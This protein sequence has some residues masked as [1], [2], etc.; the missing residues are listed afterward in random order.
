MRLVFVLFDSLNRLALQSYGGGLETPNFQRLADRSVTFDRHYVGSMPCMPARRD[1]QTGRVSFMHRSWGPL[2]PYDNSFAQILKAGGTYS[3]LVTDHFHYFEDGG[4]G[5]HTR[6]SSWDFV[7]GQEYDPWKAMVAPPLDDFARRYAAPHYDPAK[8][9]ARLHHLVNVEHMAAEADQPTP[10]CFAAAR[11]FLDTN[12]GSDNWLLQL[13][14][15]DPHEPFFAPDRFRKEGDSAYE[16]PVLNWPDYKRVTETPDEI[17]EIRANYAALVRMCDDYLGRLLD[18]FDEHDLWQDTALILS[19]DHG[20]LLSEHEWWG[21]CR[22]PYYEEVTHIP[23]FIHHPDLPDRAGQRCDAVTQTPDLMPTI[24]DIFG[25]D[26][27][28]EV[29]ARSLMPHLRGEADRDERVVAFGVFGG[30]L[31][32][33]DGRYVM[34]HYPPDTLGEGLFE[35]TLNPQHARALQRG[36]VE[37]RRD[38]TAIRLQQGDAADADQGVAGR[39]ARAQPRRPDIRGPGLCAVRPPARSRPDSPDPRRRGGGPALHGPGR[40]PAWPRHAGRGLWLVRDHA[41]GKAGDAAIPGSPKPNV[42]RSRHGNGRRPDEHAE[43]GSPGGRGGGDAGRGRAADAPSRR[44]RARR[45]LA[46]RSRMAMPRRRSSRL[47]SALQTGPAP[48]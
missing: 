39:D 1:M 26:I 48:T 31:G 23:L 20:F 41:G 11:E 18:Y 15:F 30:P 6:Y 42:R 28:A 33:T 10:R 45:R 43:D 8:K 29:R 21:K 27:P 47:W 13:E 36:R 17:A 24:L 25:C 14:L 19:T 40:H 34:F 7:R 4:A 5:Y 3:H 44:S 16:G 12:R 38:G 46:T 9:P 32:V 37:D 2:E 22:M 35:Y